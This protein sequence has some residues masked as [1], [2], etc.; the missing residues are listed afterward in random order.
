MTREGEDARNG[1]RGNE[2]RR[3]LR[4]QLRQAGWNVGATTKLATGVSVELW[5]APH[6]GPAA[7]VAPHL[8]EGIDK[9]DALRNAVAG[10]ADAAPDEP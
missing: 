2:A 3:A 1:D 5:P 7:G 6:T 9:T 8:V 4:R 10:L